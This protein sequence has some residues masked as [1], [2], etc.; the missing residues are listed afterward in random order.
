MIKQ[1]N[2]WWGKKELQNPRTEQLYRGETRQTSV[3]W[4]GVM[5]PTK[6]WHV[7]PGDAEKDRGWAVKSKKIYNLYIYNH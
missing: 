7:L 2:I 1:V 4:C 3:R 5:S 6:D